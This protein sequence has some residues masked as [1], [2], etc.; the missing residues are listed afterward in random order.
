MSSSME[1]GAEAVAVDIDA[2]DGVKIGKL[3]GREFWRILR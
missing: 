1:G 2:N 3:G